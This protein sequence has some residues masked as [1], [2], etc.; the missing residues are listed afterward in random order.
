[1]TTSAKSSMR[2]ARRLRLS[3]R[4][5]GYLPTSS[6]TRSHS[7]N[8]RLGRRTSQCEDRKT[9]S[10][11]AREKKDKATSTKKFARGTTAACVLGELGLTDFDEYEE[12]C[13]T[14]L[15]TYRVGLRLDGD[16]P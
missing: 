9:R 1:M 15:R 13:A 8:F 2:H 11:G 3:Q 4:S 12:A 16:D 5:Y 14:S 7:T 6:A 10:W